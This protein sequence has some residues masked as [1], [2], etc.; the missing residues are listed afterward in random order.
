MCSRLSPEVMSCPWSFPGRI[1]SLLPGHDRDRAP[2]QERRDR[3]PLLH[4]GHNSISDALA[5]GLGTHFGAED[6]T[7]SLKTPHGFLS[8]PL[9]I[10]KLWD[11][12]DPSLDQM[13]AKQWPN[14]VLC[15]KERPQ[16]PSSRLLGKRKTL[17]STAGVLWEAQDRLCSVAASLCQKSSEQMEKRPDRPCL[18]ST[19]SCILPDSSTDLLTG[20]RML[21]DWSYME[22]FFFL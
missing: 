8:P 9:N 15:L 1:T 11:R 12:D 16:N 7:L 6:F 3:W 22:I 2:G 17:E 19:P 5:F 21:M 20:V 10:Q 4:K 13:P 14:L 18:S